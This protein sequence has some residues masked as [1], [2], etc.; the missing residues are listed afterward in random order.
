LRRQLE[1][2]RASPGRPSNPQSKSGYA[3][4]PRSPSTDGIFITPAEAPPPGRR[5]AV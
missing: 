2:V 3:G 4:E 5:L 1:D